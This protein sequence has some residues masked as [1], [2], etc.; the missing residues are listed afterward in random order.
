MGVLDERPPFD[1]DGRVVYAVAMVVLRIEDRAAVG[2]LIG[3][4]AGERGPIGPRAIYANRS[5]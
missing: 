2:S 5:S 3:L 4:R 1:V